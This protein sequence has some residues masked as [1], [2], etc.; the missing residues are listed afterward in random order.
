[1]S[2][3]SRRD[4]I[5]EAILKFAN[6]YVGNHSIRLT[7]AGKPTKLAKGFADAILALPATNP[8]AEMFEAAQERIRVKA[9]RRSNPG[10]ETM[11]AREPKRWPRKDD[12]M[13]FLGKNG[14]EFELKAALEIF[15]TDEKYLVEDCN[16]GNWSHSVKFCGIDG[17]HNG[18]MFEL[19]QTHQTDSNTVQCSCGE[20]CMDLGAQGGCRYATPSHQRAQEE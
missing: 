9:D 8:G 5:D 7:Q 13:K 2:D 12:W 15:D 3:D 16:V 18:V 1:M 6:S 17:W 10:A 19:C 14:Y 11:V 20:E 4:E